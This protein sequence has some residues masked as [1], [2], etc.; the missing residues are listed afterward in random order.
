MKIFRHIGL[1]ACSVLFAANAQADFVFT[2]TMTGASENPVN[3]SPATGFTSVL[4]NESLTLMTVHVDWS[5]LTGGLPSAA[6]I[7]CCVA[8]GTNVGVAVGFPGFTSSLSGTYDQVFDLLNASIYTTGF[9]NN[10]GGGTAVGA[11][12]A[13][14]AGLQGGNAY[15][16]I[17]NAIFPG[18]EIRANLAP[19][20]L[21]AAAWLL[22]SGIG[23]IGTLRARR[24][25]GV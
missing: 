20:P 7:H 10:F 1:L 6:H 17:H 15:S 24:R 5:G 25:S 3:G 8:P 18:G 12:D 14:I 16:N 2:G 13:L 11:R 9:L 4:I 23:A 22:L 19:V 21:P